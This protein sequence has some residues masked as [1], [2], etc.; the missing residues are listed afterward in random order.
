MTAV[1][2]LKPFSYLL[3]R[4]DRIGVVGRNGAGKSTLLE[5][6]AGKI[7]PTAGE[8]TWVRNRKDRLFLPG[9]TGT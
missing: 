8:I 5:L 6:I 9:G 7:Q 3:G 4:E 1:T 2:I